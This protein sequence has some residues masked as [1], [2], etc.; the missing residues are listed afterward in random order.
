MKPPR[1]KAR[2]N[3]RFEALGRVWYARSV[4]DGVEIRKRANARHPLRTV[5]WESLVRL[6]DLAENDGQ[7]PLLTQNL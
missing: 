5:K 4:E 2:A 6:H 3:W 1:K 7:I